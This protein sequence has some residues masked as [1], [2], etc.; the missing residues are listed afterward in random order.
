MGKNNC[1]QTIKSW[2]VDERPR[3]RLIKFGPEN[4]SD[5][6]VLAIILGTGDAS[7][8]STA[9][10]LARAV[11]QKFDGFQGLDAAGISEICSVRGIGN[12]KAAQLKA[13]LE[14]GKR[15]LS[16]SGDAERKFNSSKDVADQYYPTLGR[17]KKEIFKALL[18]D[19]KNRVIKDVTISEGSLNASVVHPREVFNPAIKESAAGIIFVHN[20]PSG[21][22]SPSREDMD[23]TQ[24]LVKTGEVV[25]IKVID[26]I[27]LGNGQYFSFL[28]KKIL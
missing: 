15:L 9:L 16:E 3:E 2:P 8:G 24:R 26:H 18:L 19:S 10:D 23:L 7:A 13:A 6:Q 14:A 28:D 22:P 20:H 4:L 12:A 5:A 1:P 27:V 21:D 25:G 11:L 17:A